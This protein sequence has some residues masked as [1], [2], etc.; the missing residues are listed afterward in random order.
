MQY[1]RRI[2][3]ASNEASEF[4]WQIAP[5]F[6]QHLRLNAAADDNVKHHAKYP[7][8]AIIFM[9]KTTFTMQ[10][11]KMII[12]PPT[13]ANSCNGNAKLAHHLKRPTE[14]SWQIEMRT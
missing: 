2:S 10:M 14:P 5:T 8:C 11:M 12:N 1:A 13:T 6:L 3:W 9:T 7:M 4:C